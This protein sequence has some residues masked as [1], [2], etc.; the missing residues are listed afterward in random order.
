MHHLKKDARGGSKIPTNAP[1]GG[2]TR[3][4]IV[5]AQGST[6]QNNVNRG[7]WAKGQG[8]AL[9]FAESNAPGTLGTDWNEGIT[10]MNVVTVGGTN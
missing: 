3:T 4:D 7:P 10:C 2:L 1:I 8:P 5:R 9:V 6:Q